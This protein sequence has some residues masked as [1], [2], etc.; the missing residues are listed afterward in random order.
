M[1][2]RERRLAKADRLRTWADA[3]EDK[4]QAS[5]SAAN[6]LAEQIPLGQ[7][8]LVGHHSEG[9]MR[10]DFKRIDN[11]MRRSI[12]HS[13][14]A[15]EMRRRADNIESAADR[16]IFSDDDDAIVRLREKIDTLE[17]ERASIKAFNASCRAGTVN[18]DL[19]CEK[20][21][22]NYAECERYTAY[23]IGAKGEMPGYVVT[24]LS[25][26]I[27]RLKKRLIALER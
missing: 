26:N 9:R 2:Y 18:T 24:N 17:A 21:R 8:I 14:K 27:N 19:L 3:R 6:T 12:E 5:Y 15:I 1:T 22:T 23:A 10:R 13:N 11:N 4:A 7:P 25:G 20:Q 16:A